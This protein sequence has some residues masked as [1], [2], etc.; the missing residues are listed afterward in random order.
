MKGAL[1]SLRGNRENLSEKSQA[2]REELCREYKEVARALALREMLAETWEHD[3]RA[4]AEEHLEA[5]CGWASRSRLEPFRKLRASVKA[6]W[7]GI[8]GYFPDRLTSA[9]IEAINGVIQSARRR[10]RGF[11]NFENLKA[12]AYW[13]AGDLDLKIPAYP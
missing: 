7:E 10:A 11:R 4:S 13:M 3:D 8:M 2:R 5:W 1:W 6:H 12:I 9:A